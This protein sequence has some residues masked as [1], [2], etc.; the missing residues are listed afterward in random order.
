MKEIINYY[1]S[2]EI[3]FLVYVDMLLTNGFYESFVKNG[4]KY[5]VLSDIAVEVSEHVQIHNGFHLN[6]DYAA[7]Y[8]KKGYSDIQ[9]FSIIFALILNLTE[10][11]I[12]IIADKNY[13]GVSLSILHSILCGK[14][15]AKICNCLHSNI[16]DS[17]KRMI[18][19]KNNYNGSVFFRQY[20][21]DKYY[22]Y[23][24]R[25]Y[26]EKESLSQKILI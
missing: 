17:Q 19:D 16:T 18:L 13:S 5:E 9:L 25:S 21:K 8:F 11:E 2:S 20:P 23:P 14:D 7:I 1:L 12:E 26:F 3:Y 4:K 10:K 24:W 22:S 6:Y 15:L